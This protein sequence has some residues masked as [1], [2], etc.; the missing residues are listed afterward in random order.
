MNVINKLENK[1]SKL[2]KYMLNIK[3]KNGQNEI[4]YVVNIFFKM[5]GNDIYKAQ[6]RVYFWSGWGLGGVRLRMVF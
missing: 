2:Q 6:D 4:V 5:K 3:V 1:D